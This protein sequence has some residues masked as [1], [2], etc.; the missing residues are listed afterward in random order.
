[1]RSHPV[2]LLLRSFGLAAATPSERRAAAWIAVM[3][4]AGLASTFLLRPLR[5]QFGVHAGVDSYPRLY[6]W[7]LL[8]TALAVVPFW[9]LA[10]RMP[11]RR[12]VPVILHVCT[13][14]VVVLAF[15]LAAIDDYD[16]QH[17]PEVGEW[18][19]GGFS[20]LNV[21]VPTL[22][23]IH[24]VEHCRTDQA[25]RLFGL[26]AV[27]GT[28]GAVV[29]SWLAS[30]MCRVDGLALP[31][32]TAA[33]VS[34]A[35]LQGMLVAFRCSLPACRELGAATDAGRVAAGGVFEGLRILLRSGRA[36]AIGGYMMLL[37]VLATAFAAAETE[38]VGAGV[39]GSRAQ[40]G[41]L[42]DVEFWSQSL[43]LVLQL[44][45][46]GRL[47]QR[48]PAAVLLVS[49]PVVSVV[50]LAALWLAPVVLTINLVR[51]GRRG[52]QFAFEKPAREV[53]YTPLPLATK[54]KVKFLLDTFAFRLGDLFGAWLA[55]G[56]R[57]LGLGAGTAAG[58]TTVVALVWI[59]LG[60]RI[61]RR[62]RQPAS[63]S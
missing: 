34:A 58:A 33:C 53:L 7:T 15:A 55:V 60:L 17:L 31:P 61:G 8:A 49:L 12:F 46:T 39:A 38:L 4:F 51:I 44:F 23:W 11:S 48:W 24:A 14:L 41:L 63:T 50:G 20:A 21:V 13:G 57:G 9:W 3:F 62:E 30:R 56:L 40:H 16:W 5:D 47:L 22:V 59:A 19:W 26:I 37:G 32:W 25:R 45:M 52:A 28:V 18:F 43:V 6:T 29:G 27:G 10:N 35:L 54:H 42:A 1:M 2:P 36:R